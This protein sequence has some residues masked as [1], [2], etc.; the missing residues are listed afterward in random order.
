M[1]HFLFLFVCLFLF[2]QHC[3]FNV[4]VDPDTQVGDFQ[5]K[6]ELLNNGMTNDRH[7]RQ[8][9]HLGNC[10]YFFRIH[11]FYQLSYPFSTK[12]LLIVLAGFSEDSDYT[13]DLN[14]PISHNA[15]SSAS[16]YRNLRTPQRSLETSRENSYEKDDRS[17][18]SYY[19]SMATGAVTTISSSFN[20]IN[21][22][23]RSHEMSKNFYNASD[24]FSD[25][26]YKSGRHNITTDQ[27]FGDS[28][29]RNSENDPLFYNSR[30]PNTNN[31]IKGLNGSRY[32]TQSSYSG[33]HFDYL[34]V[35][36]YSFNFFFLFNSNSKT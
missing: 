3:K 1:A 17:Y 29:G 26:D 24:S 10:K 36:F 15:N 4:Q 35:I 14:Y 33:N 12:T 23:K 27:Q 22:N 18:G 11:L 20:Q 31:S 9:Q 25:M 34:T 19:D 6:L 28:S 32:G 5:R 30:P 7:H 8:V 13:S 16:Q 21:S 2:L